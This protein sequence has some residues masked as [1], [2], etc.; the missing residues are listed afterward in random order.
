M[1]D[2]VRLD[3]LASPRFSPEAQQLLDMMATLAP[4]C[5]LDADALHVRAAA[6]TGLDDFGA[7]DY[8]ER[9]EVY[10]AALRDIDGLHGAG[11][12]NFYGQL[13]QLLKNRLL[14]T[15][16]LR[17]H[18]EIDDI[19]LQPPVVIAGL[20]RTGTTHLHNLL[21]APPTFRTMPYWESVEPFPLPAE[22]GVEPDPRRA[23]MDVAVGLINTVMP[24]FPLMHEMTTEH[25]HEEIQ[26]LAND[27]STM[28]FET[29]ADVPRWRAYY[30]AHDQT[31]HYEYLARQ[32]KAMQ[33]LRGGRRWLLKS[34]QHL[35][36][37]P[38]L[39]R[40]FPGSIVVFTHRDPVPV[41]LSMIAMI[42]YSAR[43]HRSP[44]PV[45]EI[46]AS[47]IDRLEDMLSALVRDRETIGPERSIDIR[48]DDFMSN[49]IGVAERVYA[50]AG[51][52]F[53]DEARTAIADYLAVHRRGRLGNV[54]T[55]CEMF[56]LAEADLRRRFAPY[57]K[58]F[59]A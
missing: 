36:Q 11:V 57:V 55:S 4:D 23:R 14:L 16:L 6:D 39:D 3:D 58:R 38:V 29:L 32:L 35:E 51:E 9:L 30:Q 48:F 18:P 12:V 25:V 40:V 54:A 27:F 5:P 47:W 2:A 1:T 13:L 21:A 41:A 52:P 59:L 37:V 20:P 56:G 53:T 50:L 22:A 34:P 45:P 24:H 19:E 10:L 15:D 44:V 46:A 49:E 31:P 43:M 28:L 7:S 26:L 17:R 8:R 33:F 42:T